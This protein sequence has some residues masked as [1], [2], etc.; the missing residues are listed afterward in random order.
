MLINNQVNV[1]LSNY[2]LNSL[3]LSDLLIKTLIEI[4]YNLIPRV[5]IEETTGLKT[6]KLK[7]L[8]TQTQEEVFHTNHHR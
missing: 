3:S 6:D 1:S 5:S 2:L 4:L 7:N 8:I